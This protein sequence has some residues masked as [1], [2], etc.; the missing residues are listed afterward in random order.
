MVLTKDFK[1]F[2]DSLNKNNVQ[3]PVIGGYAVAFHGHSHHT[4][5]ICQ[6]S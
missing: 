6:H 1:E 5:N 3:Y 4:K 2:I